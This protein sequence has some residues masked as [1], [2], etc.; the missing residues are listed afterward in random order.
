MNISRTGAIALK[1]CEDGRSS[2][3]VNAVPAAVF[4]EEVATAFCDAVEGAAFERNTSPKGGK[5]SLEKVLIDRR[6]KLAVEAS[7]AHK[8]IN[9]R[10]DAPTK[11]PTPASLGIGSAFQQPAVIQILFLS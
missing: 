10:K 2:L 1:R 4:F 3:Y 6:V 11:V 9:E 7:F 8:K 5:I